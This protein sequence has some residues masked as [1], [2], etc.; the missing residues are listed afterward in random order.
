MDS[1][2]ERLFRH[3][4][5]THRCNNCRQRFQR[6][7]FSVVARH[8]RLWVV[9]ARC[10]SCHTVRTFWVPFRSGGHPRMTEVTAAEQRRLDTLPI[11]DAD[12][13]LNMHEF[14]ASFDGDFQSLFAEK[15]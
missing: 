13:V 2:Q 3:L 9:S 15:I 7:R 4:L 1:A 5:V 14:L 8:D 12:D 11:L 6:D 10:S